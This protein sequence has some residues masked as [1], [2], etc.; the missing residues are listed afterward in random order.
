MREENV[1]DNCLPPSDGLQRGA[2]TE[3]EGGS[4]PDSQ[5]ICLFMAP[6]MNYFGHYFTSISPATKHSKTMC[7]IF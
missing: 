7:Q 3:A 5:V 4:L 2:A 1:S 6:L